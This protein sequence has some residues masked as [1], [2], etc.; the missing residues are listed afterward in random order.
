MEHGRLGCVV[1]RA[2]R[3]FSA[4]AVST[5]HGASEYH[6]NERQRNGDTGIHSYVPIP[7]FILLGILK[8]APCSTRSPSSQM[9]KKELQ[10]DLIRVHLRSSV[11]L[12]FTWVGFALQRR[13]LAEK[14]AITG[15]TLWALKKPIIAQCHFGFKTTIRTDCHAE[16]SRRDQPRSGDLR[17][18]DAHEMPKLSGDPPFF[19]LP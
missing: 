1:K 13:N 9:L 5:K 2:S 4:E 10:P 11:V 6:S 17:I 15:L 8:V 3:L 14:L 7:L 16:W 18:A 19:G 12:S